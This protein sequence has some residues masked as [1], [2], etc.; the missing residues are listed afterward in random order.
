MKKYIVTFLLLTNVFLNLENSENPQSEEEFYDEGPL[1]P[2]EFNL[3][4]EEDLNLNYEEEE[5]FE[6]NFYENDF[7]EIN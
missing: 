2:S 6:N 5:D 4:E 3:E 7:Q 1:N